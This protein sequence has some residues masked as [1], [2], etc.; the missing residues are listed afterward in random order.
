MTLMTYSAPLAQRARSWLRG[1]WTIG[2]AYIVRRTGL[3]WRI[4][5]A[6]TR[7]P[8]CHVGRFWSEDRAC[9]IAMALSDALRAGWFSRDCGESCR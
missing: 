9:G 3:I 7:L 8:V 2:G 5:D 4:H 6:E 1:R